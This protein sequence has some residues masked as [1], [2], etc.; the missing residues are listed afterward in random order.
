MA[1]AEA[2]ALGVPVIVSDRV[3]IWPDVETCSGGV[4]IKHSSVPTCLDNIII[5][6]LA[7]PEGSIEMG[8]RAQIFANENYD[9][10]KTAAATYALYERI[11]QHI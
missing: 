5:S 11:L 4:V 1:A 2:M 7:D 6:R 10:H 9:W 3:N 8:R